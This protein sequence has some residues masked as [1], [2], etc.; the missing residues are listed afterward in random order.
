MGAEFQSPIH[1]S[2]AF[3]F[4]G[5]AADTVPVSIPYTRVINLDPIKYSPTTF[6]VSIPYT[7]VI[8]RSQHRI[9]LALSA[10]SIPYT[11]VINKQPCYR[12]IYFPACFN[13]LYTGHKLAWK[14][15]IL[16]VIIGFN[17]LYTGHK[18]GLLSGPAL[19]IYSFNPLYTGHKRASMFALNVLPK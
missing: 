14:K 18:Q 9:E 10:V 1:G 7:R 3:L 2:Q 5:R 11:R 8:N 13:P 16:I 17:P 15:H 19:D 6:I 4:P 12:G